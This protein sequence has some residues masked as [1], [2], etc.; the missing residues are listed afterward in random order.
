MEN[1]IEKNY[2]YLGFW[3]RFSIRICFILVFTI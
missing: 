1:S 2:I 3:L